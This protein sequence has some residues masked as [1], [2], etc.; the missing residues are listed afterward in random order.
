MI[1]D[2]YLSTL[3]HLN[4]KHHCSFTLN[5]NYRNKS[6]TFIYCIYLNLFVYK[7]HF[8]DLRNFTAFKKVFHNLKL[9]SMKIK[10]QCYSKYLV[11]VSIILQIHK[12]Y[13]KYLSLPLPFAIRCP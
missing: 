8:L 4:E 10:R 1:F 9:R 13:F 5:A 3:L 11:T 7:H 2:L 12:K 6:Q